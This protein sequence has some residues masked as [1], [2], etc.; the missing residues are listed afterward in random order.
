M[1]IPIGSSNAATHPLRLPLLATGI[2]GVAGY[3]AFLSL[4]TQFPGQVVGLR[5]QQTFRLNG[6]GIVALDADDV[7]GLRDLCREW[8][9]ES[10]LNCVGNC[11][12]KSCELDPAMSHRLNVVTAEAIARQSLEL[13]ARL[14]HLSSDLV[15]SGDSGIGNYR[16]TDPTDPVTVYGKTMVQGEEL[17]RD[18]VPGAAI[19]RISLPMGPSFNGHAGAIDW[20]DSR[21]RAN[22]PA[23]LYYDEVRSATYVDDLN[24]VFAWLLHREDVG[25]VF[26]AGGP[27]AI[28]LNQIGQVVNRVGGY[29]PDLLH[30]CLRHQAGPVP[31]RAGN[32]SMNSGKL[33]KAMGRQPFRPWPF[34]EHCVPKHRRWHHERDPEE[35]GSFE[36]IERELYRYHCPSPLLQGRG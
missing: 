4:R 33:I 1:E 16:E 17:I 21:F 23:T 25:G 14:V 31:P 9:F 29:A 18:L 20:I 34:H 32:V 6:D 8:R 27:R 36:R 22:R 30:G 5:P 12:L 10:I 7:G 3:N 35:T 28:T 15:F 2:T 24:E 13:G 19:V 26:H 11:A